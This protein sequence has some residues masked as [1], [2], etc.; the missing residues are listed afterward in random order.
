M[1]RDVVQQLPWG[2]ALEKFSRNNQRGYYGDEVR[3]DLLLEAAEAERGLGPDFL[4]RCRA[5][6]AAVDAAAVC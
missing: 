4:P 5:L 6:A 3:S 1:S 2:G